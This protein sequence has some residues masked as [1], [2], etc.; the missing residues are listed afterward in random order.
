MRRSFSFLVVWLTLLA[1]PVQS[2]AAALM[3]FCEATHERT[4]QVDPPCAFAHAHAHAHT[5]SPAEAQAD[6]A[7]SLAEPAEGSEPSCSACAICSL[8]LATPVEWAAQGGL[9]PERWIG[10]SPD[11]TTTSHLPDGLERPPR[12][13]AA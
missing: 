5:L 2:M 9:E 13:F 7:A 4:L 10:S 3:V 1:V 12:D 11:S 6:R 8:M